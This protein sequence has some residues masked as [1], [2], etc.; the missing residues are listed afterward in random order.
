YRLVALTVSLALIG[1]VT[2]GSLTGS[3]L[4]FVLRRLGF[5]PASASAPFVA[6]L[7]DV[8]GLVIYFTV[9]LL[10]LRGTLL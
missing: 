4:P 1:V 7:V 10:L 6:T 9:A 8:T 2:F 5:D 3:M